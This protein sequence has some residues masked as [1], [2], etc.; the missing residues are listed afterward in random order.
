MPRDMVANK[1]GGIY[2][3]LKHALEIEQQFYEA[4]LFEVTAE[5]K[6]KPYNQEV[7]KLVDIILN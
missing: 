3:E 4:R 5:K 1:F 7:K 2:T 6:S